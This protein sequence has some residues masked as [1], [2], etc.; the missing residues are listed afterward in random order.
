MEQIKREAIEPIKL[1]APNA[2]SLS[3][4]SVTY[5]YFHILTNTVV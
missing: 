4:K 2:F 1:P 5:Y 3:A